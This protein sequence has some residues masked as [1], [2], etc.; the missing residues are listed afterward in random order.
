MMKHGLN[1]AEA[2][3]L[4]SID[5]GESDRLLTFY[6][7]EHGKLK[8]VAKGARR[9]KKRFVGNLEPGSSVRLI[10]FNNEK[11][12]LVRIESAELAEGLPGLRGD[13]EA[14]ARACYMLELACELTR[15]GCAVESAY[16]VL[17]A[18]LKMLDGKAAASGEEAGDIL[19]F[20]EI[21][22]L[23]S[24]G[25]MPHLDGCV[26]CR[27]ASFSEGSTRAFFSPERGGAVCG[28]C[29]REAHGL[30]QLTA[31]T[32]TALS[33]AARLAPEKLARLKPGAAFARE[34]ERLLDAFIRH[35][36]GKELKT[37]RFLEKLGLPARAPV[38]A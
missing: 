8:G 19:R 14:Y 6:T 3:I 11:S 26:S 7:L 1:T 5:F 2:V 24:L 27:G 18:F 34:S 37:K 32:L 12:E 36:I 23:A 17:T 15:E 21:K 29:A 35:I 16:L 13:I 9:S 25:Y 20:F 38:M 30:V 10:F 28:A 33:A 22:L 4:G 31:G